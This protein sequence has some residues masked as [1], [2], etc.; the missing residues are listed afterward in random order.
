MQLRLSSISAGAVLAKETGLGI[1][2]FAESPGYF[3]AER[4]EVKMGFSGF[5][6]I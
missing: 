4:A 3:S 5:F 1:L 6:W 2:F